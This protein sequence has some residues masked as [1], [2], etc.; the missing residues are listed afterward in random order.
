METRSF[1]KD[2]KATP[3][4]YPTLE[5]DAKADVVIVGGG[6][7]GIILAEKLLKEGKSVILLEAREIAGSTSGNSTGNLYVPV[8]PYYHQITDKFDQHTTYAAMHSRQ[9]AIDH[10]EALVKE[11]EIEC[12][13]SRRP[14]YMYTHL[15]DKLHLLRDEL[16]SFERCDMPVSAQANVPFDAPIQAIRMDGAARFNPYAFVTE[17][18]KKLS[19]HE[20]CKI[21]EHSRVLDFEQEGH[22][23]IVKL[24]NAT[25]KAGAAVLA[26][27]VPLGINPLHLKNFAYRSYVVAAELEGECPDGNFWELGESGITAFSSH[28]TTGEKLDLMMV[29]GNHHKV[30][31]GGDNIDR[32]QQLEDLL[33]ERFNVKQIKYRWSA[34]HYASADGLPYIGQNIFTMDKIYCATGFGTDGL[35]YGAVSALLLADM[36]THKTNPLADVYDSSRHKLFSTAEK[37]INEN[38]NVASKYFE[39]FIKADYQKEIDEVRIGE[40][41]VLELKDGKMAVYKDEKGEAHVVSAI[42]PHMKCVVHW[43]NAEKTWDCPCHGSRFD[44][45][46]QVLEGPSFTPL[47]KAR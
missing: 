42:C 39:D 35:T 26:T 13:F 18:A 17:L 6:I 32:Y 23:A 27:H 14:W 4:V 11:Y 24:E 1:W 16:M 47:K 9:S 21:Y 41:K 15:P 45:D 10:V 40:G 19:A 25:V 31:Q 43:N 33:R 22:E 46:G 30:G 2:I 44:I 7:T 28:S 38:L 34:Q 3:K 29:A 37:L 8:Q 5:S 20:N 12:M 36:I